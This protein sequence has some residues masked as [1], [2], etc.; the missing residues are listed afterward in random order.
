MRTT[1]S[2]HIVGLRYYLQE[3]V[4]NS[5]L[6]SKDSTTMPLSGKTVYL[7]AD[8]ECEQDDHAVMAYD[9]WGAPLGHVSKMEA[10]HYACILAGDITSSIQ[11]HI[12]GMDPTRH[13]LIVE[14]E[15]MP[16]TL[17]L[18]P[19]EGSEWKLTL[20]NTKLPHHLAQANHA[21]MIAE[22]MAM[23]HAE[24]S[25]GCEQA[26]SRL[27]E[28]TTCDLAGDT[29]R[30]R[31]T[32]ARLCKQK[33][34]ERWQQAGD[35]LMAL[36]DHMGGDELM[37]HWVHHT[38]PL[39]IA[40][41]KV[42]RLTRT[43]KDYT[44]AQLTDALLTCPREIGREWLSGNHMLFAKRLYYAQLPQQLVA[45]ILVLVAMTRGGDSSSS[46]V[47]ELQELLP[48]GQSKT[49]FDFLHQGMVR[50]S[51]NSFDYEECRRQ[52][53]RSVDN[54]FDYEKQKESASSAQ[55]ASEKS[56]GLC[57]PEDTEEPV[58][59]S[60]RGAPCGYPMKRTTSII[61]H[62]QGM[63]LQ[64]AENKESA[65]SAP[66]KI[67]EED[68]MQAAHSSALLSEASLLHSC[69]PERHSYTPE[70]LSCTPEKL[71]CTP[72]ESPYFRQHAD[73]A[74]AHMRDMK[75]LCTQKVDWL[76]FYTVLLR[77][78]WVEENLS[79]FCRMVGDRF[80]VSLDN[81]TLSRD[82]KKNGPDY[83]LWIDDNN[84]ISRR[85][86]LAQEFDQ[87]LTEYFKRGREEVMK[88]VR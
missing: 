34:D 12:V 49:S 76:S 57:H 62:P 83:T 42:Q 24:W 87:H 23:T 64:W 26:F 71:S 73:V 56:C 20:M 53:C 11:G 47:Q 80:G 32:L 31:V 15:E 10:D 52:E 41:D 79:A 28:L 37:H 72:K 70:R 77:R 3:S 61:G 5:L 18:R 60:R 8:L 36:I 29:Y 30:K 50:S 39:L 25:T 48:F 55:S 67:E 19:T 22:R 58:N 1:N 63:P 65:S 33:S 17:P 66:K 84:R 59:V 40:D 35:R 9:E 45:Q 54:S 14:I 51:D 4:L 6:A 38:L 27:M 85:K 75:P 21:L 46:G 68:T 7:M 82:L 13:S 86:R 74:L 88:G 78:R 43:Y 2:A 69:T 16:D 44:T 81:R